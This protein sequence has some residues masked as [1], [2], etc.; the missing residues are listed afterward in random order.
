MIDT[1]VIDIPPH[2]ECEDEEPKKVES[3]ERGKTTRVKTLTIE[4]SEEWYRRRQAKP[5]S[6]E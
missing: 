6:K 4:D 2:N 3:T 1:T 5:V